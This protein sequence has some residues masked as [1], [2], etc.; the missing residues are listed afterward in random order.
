VA[1]FH[2]K[3]LEIIQPVIGSDPQLYTY[4]ITLADASESDIR[5]LQMT[6][7]YPEQ[8][9]AEDICLFIKGT[10]DPDTYDDDTCEF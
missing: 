7:E 1:L 2:L 3:R 8:A 4:N 6:T 9:S 10:L 5:T